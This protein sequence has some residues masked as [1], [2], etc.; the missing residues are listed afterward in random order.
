LAASH[1]VTLK[2]KNPVNSIQTTICIDDTPCSLN[3]RVTPELKGISAVAINILFTSGTVRMTFSSDANA[4]YASHSGVTPGTTII[5][6]TL[7]SSGRISDSIRLYTRS[8]PSNSIGDSLVF[9][10]R[11]DY[12]AT[13]E[14]TISP[15][16][17]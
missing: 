6:A 9:E 12:V 2:A 5:Q 14:V 15:Q 13:L 7:D 4:L 16:A 8:G 3:L 1:V 11:P 17:N 10:S